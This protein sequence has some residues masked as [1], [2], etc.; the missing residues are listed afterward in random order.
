[1]NAKF[2]RARLR[3]STPKGGSTCED[4]TDLSCYR[5]RYASRIRNRRVVMARDKLGEF[6]RACVR[7]LYSLDSWARKESSQCPTLTPVRSSFSARA[8]DMN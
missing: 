3:N 5:R 4:L 8:A 2:V 6:L 7:N 1:M